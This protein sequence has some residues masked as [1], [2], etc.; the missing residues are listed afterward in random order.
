MRRNRI[1]YLIW[2]GI[3]AVCLFFSGWWYLLAVLTGQAAVALLMGFLAGWDADKVHISAAWGTVETEEKQIPLVLTVQTSGR[4]L[5]S[6]SIHLE[7]E[8]QYRMFQKTVRR[9]L[10]LPLQGAQ[11]TYRLPVDAGYCGE[12]SAVCI[13]AEVCDLLKLFRWKTEFFRE[14]RTVIWPRR[15]NLVVEPAKNTI[16]LPEH[17]GLLQNRKG[18]DPREVFDIREYLPG[19]DVRSIHWKLSGKLDDLIV[20]EASDPTHY[21]TAI[22]PDLGL[23]QGAEPV[24]REELNRAVAVGASICGK[25]LETGSPMCM[26]LLNGKGLEVRKIS[27]RKEWENILLQWLGT[28]VPQKAGTALQYFKLEHMEQYFSRL[29]ILTAGKYSESVKPLKGK[30][31]ISIV[32]A[33]KDVSFT[34]TVLGEGCEVTELPSEWTENEHYRIYC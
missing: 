21:H 33:V 16:G 28:G 20:R 11:T 14:K 23:L 8:I 19:D 3:L 31:G 26:L 18:N 30:I 1:V 25:L 13:N 2:M 9:A 32:E 6:G 12:A 7:L 22:L 4:L 17:E 34:H 5:A 10:I 15:V 24:S 29:L 27:S